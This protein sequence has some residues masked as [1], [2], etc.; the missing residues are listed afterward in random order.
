MRFL[1]FFLAPFFAAAQGNMDF[2][3]NKLHN[4]SAASLP[5]KWDEAFPLGNGTL[6]A[7]VWQ[8]DSFLRLSLDRADLWDDRPMKGLDRPEFRYKWVQDQVKK[9]Q[10]ATVQKYFDEPYEAEPAPTKLPGAA[11]EFVQNKWGTV[12]ATNL[13]IQ[14]GEVTVSYSNQVKLTTFVHATEEVGWFRLENVDTL[15]IRLIPPKYVGASTA[16]AGSVTGDDLARLGYP[17]GKHTKGKLWKYYEQK[18]HGGFTYGVMVRWRYAQNR[19][20]EGVWTIVP[21]VDSAKSELHPSANA[22]V[23]NYQKELKIHA[24]WWSDYW[25]KSQISLPDSLLERQYYLDMYKFGSAARRGSPPISLQAIWTADN[26]RLPPWKGDFH[27][28]LNTQLSYW[29]AY[30]SNHLQES[31]SYVDHLDD[32]WD[33]YKKYTRQYFEAEGINVPGVTTLSGKPMGGWIQYACSPTVSAWLSQHYYL[34]WRY[35]MNRRFLERRAYPWFRNTATFLQQV[36]QTNA[37]GNLQL[38][39]SS[40]PEYNDNSLNAWFS[41][42]TN[43]DNALIHFVFQKSAELARELQRNEE[44]VRWDSIYRLLPSLEI[45]AKEGLLIAKDHKLKDSHRHFSHLMAIH[46]LGLLNYEDQKERS[47]IQNS[48][49]HLDKIGTDYWTGYSFAWLG[50]LKARAKDGE[51]ARDALKIFASAF[52]SSNSFHV[53]GDQSKKGYSKYTYRPFTLEGNFASAA[54]ILEMLL[55]SHNGFV[56][57]FPAIPS[58]WKNVSFHQ[59]RAEGG[60]LVSATKSEGMLDKVVITAE[61]STEFTFQLP[62]KTWFVDQKMQSK[63]TLT[64][65]NRLKITLQ[66]GETIEVKNGYE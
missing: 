34:Q 66:K 64:P 1:L 54:G 37:A 65:E 24:K 45:D 60:L 40:S 26:G 33:T 36:L 20:Y 15:N 17:A 44:A 2:L 42:P 10:Y 62:F 55:Q 22:M 53:N 12:T 27:H 6:G 16:A 61:T 30:K 49:K 4:L 47:I 63:V 32:N 57:V 9:K 46:P 21:I 5:T 35:G 23:S 51:G 13:N 58:D 3:P 38:P 41:T 28:D 14:N 25:K 50:N 19:C 56:E 59:L 52:C 8:K 7:L 31:Y 43:Y 29:P 48:L 18:G 39:I 11:I